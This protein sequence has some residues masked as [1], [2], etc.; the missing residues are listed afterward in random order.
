MWASELRP[1]SVVRFAA[2]VALVVILATPVPVF[3]ASSTAG[4]A[5]PN[6]TESGTCGVYGMAGPQSPTFTI[7]DRI[8][9]PFA[10]FFGRS[11]SQVSSSMVDWVEPSGRL[12]R[13][14]SRALAAFQSAAQNINASGAG[15]TVRTGAAFNWRNIAASN[16]MSHHAVGNAIDINPPQNPVTNGVL[17]T[18]M[19]P[20]YRQAWTAAGFCWG[21]S[22]RFSKDSMHYAWRGPAAVAGL[23]TRITPYAPLTASADFTT[24]ALDAPA[25]VA[26][27]DLYAMSGKRRDGGDDLYGL[28]PVNGHWQMQVA[29]A[30]ARFGVLGVR[31]TTGAPTGG[32]PLLADAN[33]DG[34]A[35]LWRFSTGGPTITADVYLDS[36]RFRSIGKQ[37]TTGAAWSADAELGLAVFDTADWVPD[38]YVIRRNTGTVEVYSSASGYQQLIHTSNLSIPVGSSQIVLADRDVDG[39]TDIWLVGAGNSARVDVVFWSGGYGGTPQTTNTSMSVPSG[40]K[41]LPGD[42]DGDGRV[43]LYVVAG[44]RVSVWLGGVPD[45]AIDDLG[46]WFTPPGP[47][48]FDAGP[49][50]AGECDQIGYVDE[51]GSW[52]MAH[53]VAWAPFESSFYYGNPSDSPFMGDWD[54][55]GV[56]TPGLY[57]RS[58]GFVYL[59]NSNTQGVADIKFFFGNPSDIPIPGDF[60]EDGCDTVSIYRP[61]EQRFYVINRLG[62]GDAGL[63]AADFSF[64]FGNPGDK[65]FVG[66]FDGNGI[67]EVG[68]HRE[69]TGRVYFRFSL[70]T[71]IADNQFFFGD[72]GDFLVAGDWEGDG[73]DTPA[74]FRPSDGNWYLRLSNTQGVADH[75]IPFGL[76]DRDLLPVVGRNGFFSVFTPQSGV[77][78]VPGDTDLLPSETD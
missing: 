65:P 7:G 30:G 49:V 61:A 57:R 63:G 4:D 36:S 12:F 11:R 6:F 74:I 60:D 13:V 35:D 71:G 39:S 77:E 19:P 76:A 37:V 52:R 69:S 73:V 28:V 10:D 56:D 55:D 54:C 72:P 27:A 1:R 8:Y 66:D 48:T 70:S 16:Q 42:Y 43:D 64:L 47:N 15:Y 21:G 5:T 46:V 53:E 34:R 75:V 20:V 67:D 38:L 32:I 3:A 2:T 9:G 45:R 68:L 51:G 40:A 26:G 17:I 14:H 22:W 29:G 24:V 59:R 33:G 25:A 31:W 78:T 50:C 18:D 62:S 44:G 41:V 58:D 23:M